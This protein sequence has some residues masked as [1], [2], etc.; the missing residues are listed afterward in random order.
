[1]VSSNQPEPSRSQSPTKKMASNVKSE[2]E[3]DHLHPSAT[4]EQGQD[5]VNQ[6]QS[7][8]VL[9]SSSSPNMMTDEL[10]DD[11][12]G[13][14]DDVSV[15]PLASVPHPQQ[16][17]S[18]PAGALAHQS[19]Y[20]MSVQPQQ[21]Q[22]LLKLKTEHGFGSPSMNTPDIIMTHDDCDEDPLSSSPSRRGSLEVA[23]M[24]SGEAMMDDDHTH[25]GQ[26]GRSIAPS[27]ASSAAADTTNTV[28]GPTAPSS[29]RPSLRTMTAT[30]PRSALQEETIALFKQYRNLIP[31]AKCFCRNTIQRDGMSDGNLRFKCRPPVSMSLICNKSYSESKIRNMI[32]GV[33]YGHSLPDSNTSASGTDPGENVL[34]LAPPPIVKAASSRRGSKVDN[35]LRN[36]TEMTPDK[37]Q[38]RLQQQQQ[39]QQQEEEQETRGDQ[40]HDGSD[41]AS[42]LMDARRSSQS[43]HPQQG[44]SS[45]RG[46]V[47]QQARRSSMV[48][49]ESMMMDYDDPSQHPSSH[50][51][52]LQVPSTPPMD[53]HDDSRF[54]RSRNGYNRSA[55]STGPVQS[56]SH[57]RH[58]G[59]SSSTAAAG[60]G[61]QLHKLHHSHSHPNI[62]QARHQQY[63][64][65]QQELQREHRGSLTSM[66]YAAQ[67]P[68]IDA[69]VSS[70]STSQ[71]QHR[72]AT[73]PIVRR[74]SSQY[75]GSTE[76]RSSHPS[77]IMNNTGSKHMADALSPGLSA[78]PRSSPGREAMYAHHYQQQSPIP[79]LDPSVSR[80]PHV[81]NSRFEESA[82]YFQRRMSQPHTGHPFN[83][84]GTGH[85]AGLPPPM[86]SPLAHHPYDRRASEAE[87]YPQMHREKYERLN[88]S[89][90]LAPSSALGSSSSRQQ[91]PLSQKMRSH[92]PPGSPSNGMHPL[93]DG[94]DS[95]AEDSSR[96]ALTPPM[97]AAQH[98]GQTA[99]SGP[100]PTSSPW[101]LGSSQAMSSATSPSTGLHAEP[102]R[103]SHST[104]MNASRPPLRQHHSTSSLYYQTP[105]PDEKDRDRFESEHDRGVSPEYHDIDTDGRPIARMRPQGVKR[106]SLGQSLSRSSS[107]QNLYSTSSHHYQYQHHSQHHHTHQPQQQPHQ[108]ANFRRNSSSTGHASEHS[109]HSPHHHHH[110]HHHRDHAPTPAQTYA[111][112]LNTAMPPGRIGSSSIKLTCFPSGNSKTTSNPQPTIKTLVDDTDAAIAMKLNQSS[113]LVIEIQQ[114]WT[115][116]SYSSSSTSATC[117]SLRDS[118]S[119]SEDSLSKTLN[120]YA[121]HAAELTRSSPTVLGY[122]RSS[123]SSPDRM[124]FEG[125]SLNKKRRGDSDMVPAGGE[126]ASTSSST[127]EAAAAAIVAAA[128]AATVA[129]TPSQEQVSA[130]GLTS[131]N[132]HDGSTVHVF[133]MEYL[134][135]NDATKNKLSQQTA[136]GIGLGLSTTGS[137]SPIVDALRV[138]KGSSYGSIED[139]QKEMGIDYSLFTRVETAGWRIL[140]PPNVVASFRSEDFGLM[141]RPKGLIEIE[142]Q[143]LQQQGGL[144]EKVQVQNGE[145]RLQDQQKQQEEEEEDVNVEGVR[146]IAL[147]DDMDELEDEVRIIEECATGVVVQS[148]KDD[149]LEMQERTAAAVV[150][151]AEQEKETDMNHVKKREKLLQDEDEQEQDELE[152]D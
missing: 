17:S 1:M 141:L 139:Q 94:P 37:L 12:M 143:G 24:E 87:E 103:Y 105:R 128:A 113:K 31:C 67:S 21:H 79:P 11:P 130:E 78:S 61:R 16:Q 124:D 148:Q 41:G 14:S 149:D 107:N 134:A 9:S 96:Q 26:S 4:E 136:A 58:Q 104:P 109:S 123:P 73:R 7:A 59:S 102:M 131:G 120:G 133:G 95:S 114:P 71:Q 97:R 99:P 40:S 144:E 3:H 65:Q 92:Y 70:H 76:R 10:E 33:V 8:S 145:H 129:V 106:K 22:Q 108:I 66:N 27:F 47:Q 13:Y 101:N 35:S 112:D 42:N 23:S 77:P 5:H 62:G 6:R 121:S 81:N 86:P 115:L 64:E 38:Q 140:I 75:L 84:N 52:H 68:Q 82:G 116:Q 91:P 152:D 20:D 122:R 69:Q 32:A 118:R 30:L 45:R 138:A 43:L 49:D 93:D 80:G 119:N 126:S 72:S 90:M 51:S 34:A 85:S 55:T 98:L 63:L 18:P 28:A 53:G 137:I 132:D 151:D 125:G 44:N 57:Q 74:D 117:Q 89:T 54:Y 83:N 2:P 147:R 29:R 110:H 142:D 88:A 46:S 146:R 135:K 48:G 56:L 19:P 15:H 100:S 25:T 150:A 36:G 50:S 111:R 127:T 60:G 39:R